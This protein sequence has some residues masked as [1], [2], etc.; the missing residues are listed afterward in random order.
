MAMCRDLGLRPLVVARSLPSH[1]M[2]MLYEAGGLGWIVGKQ[3][4]PFGQE[5]LAEEV[6]RELGYQIS[7]A[8]SIEDGAVNRFLSAHGALLK[9]AVKRVLTA[10]EALIRREIRGR[11]TAKKV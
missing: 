10:G 11:K 8:P 5:K 4:W 7:C 2:N 1:Y 9:R 6:R 3:A